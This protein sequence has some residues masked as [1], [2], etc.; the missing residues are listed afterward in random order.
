[1]ADSRQ[2]YENASFVSGVGFSN[3][4]ICDAMWV[5]FINDSFCFTFHQKK[6]HWWFISYTIFESKNITIWRYV[7]N[8]NKSEMNMERSNNKITSS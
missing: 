1:M 7:L 6:K 2:D 8:Y 3:V 5:L 4:Q